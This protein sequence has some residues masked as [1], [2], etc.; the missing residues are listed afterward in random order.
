MKVKI[1]VT[2]E[3]DD[4]SWALEYGLNPLKPSEIRDD[5]KWYCEQQIRESYAI[6]TFSIAKEA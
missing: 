5:V 1:S 6:S 4:D 2:V 3:I